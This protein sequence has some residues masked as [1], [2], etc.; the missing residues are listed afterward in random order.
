MATT[1]ASALASA[2]EQLMDTVAT[3]RWS[4]DILKAW[5]LEAEQDLITRCPWLSTSATL[6]GTLPTAAPTT[7]LDVADGCAQ[8]VIDW[9][10]WRAFTD[11]AEAASVATGEMHR[12]AYEAFIAAQKKR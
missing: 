3:Y 11:D 9:T 5:F 12:K 8:A 2:R 1:T 10:C 6:L 4:D 7:N